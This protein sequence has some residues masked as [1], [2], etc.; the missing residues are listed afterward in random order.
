MEEDANPEGKRGLE[1][2]EETPR[3]PGNYF[4]KKINVFLFNKK[5]IFKIQ[6]NNEQ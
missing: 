5:K 1:Q 2:S 4:G 3:G 6:K